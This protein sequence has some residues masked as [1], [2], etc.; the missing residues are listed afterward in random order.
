VD[1]SLI[2]T[3]EL[4]PVTGTPF[5]FRRPTAI[6]DRIEQDD[7]QLQRGR[8][9]DHNFV[10]NHPRGRL[11]LV[12]RVTELVTGR[13]MEVLTT[14]PGMQLYTGNFLD[15]TIKGKGGQVYR[16]RSGFCLE[17]QHFPD[18][19]NHPEFPSVTLKTGQLYQQTVIFRFP[20][21]TPHGSN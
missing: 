13:V 19:P 10:L 12:A 7:E 16:K 20:R 18:S 3:G 9:Y 15:G 11:D 8:G 14:Q 4:R 6:G 17:A 2:P 1:S 21:P 5:D